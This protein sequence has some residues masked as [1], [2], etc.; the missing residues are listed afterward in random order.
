M[1]TDSKV[2]RSCSIRVPTAPNISPALAARVVTKATIPKA[3]CVSISGMRASRSPTT[4]I[5]AAAGPASIAR[6]PAN[7]DTPVAATRTA[8]DISVR[9]PA[10][11]SKAGVRGPR[12]TAAKPST[13]KVPAKAARAT[14]TPAISN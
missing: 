3:S 11:P 1:T 12:T 4:A 9:A 13:T 10:K 14:P 8:K 2:S 5:P 7:T 6:A